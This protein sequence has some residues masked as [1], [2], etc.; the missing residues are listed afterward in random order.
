MKKP[1][2]KHPPTIP[3][4]LHHPDGWTNLP[5][6][7]DGDY[8]FWCAKPW[9]DEF[10]WEFPMVVRVKGGIRTEEY[11]HDGRGWYPA[12][13]NGRGEDPVPVWSSEEQ[14]E[15]MSV[16]KPVLPG[17][18]LSGNPRKPEGFAALERDGCACQNCD[19][20]KDD[21]WSAMEFKHW[22]YEGPHLFTMR[23]RHCP[24]CGKSEVLGIGY[25]EPR[26][27]REMRV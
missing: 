18:S 7:K 26:F 19:Q 20:G 12:V 25:Y 2:P 21:S 8:W 15:I 23:F 6:T 13:E 9:K 10:F 11:E 24:E 3:S 5:P 4:L 27:G 22:F 1:V 14:H 16:W 17:E